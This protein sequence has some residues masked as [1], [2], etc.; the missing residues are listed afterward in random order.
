MFRDLRDS[1]GGDQPPVSLSNAKYDGSRPV[2]TPLSLRACWEEGIEP[3][4]LVKP[5]AAD[6]YFKEGSAAGGNGGNAAADGEEKKIPKPPPLSAEKQKLRLEHNERVRQRL[7]V[8]VRSRYQMLQTKAKE[9]T[10]TANSTRKPQE[11]ENSDESTK[12]SPRIPLPPIS[13]RSPLLAA[14]D[15]EDDEDELVKAFLVLK[16]SAETRNRTRHALE[17]KERHMAEWA[18]HVEEERRQKSEAAAKAAETQR[19]KTLEAYERNQRIR[20]LKSLK[21]V[22]E[23]EKMIETAHQHAKATHKV[24]DPSRG[25]KEREMAAKADAERLANLQTKLAKAQ[26]AAQRKRKQEER[27]RELKAFQQELVLETQ[28]QQNERC[29][30]MLEF[31]KSRIQAKMEEEEKR[32]QEASEA[33]RAKIKASMLARERIMREKEEVAKY[34]AECEA[35]GLETIDAPEW[36]KDSVE[37]YHKRGATGTLSSTPR[38]A[39]LEPRR[40]G[41]LAGDASPSP[42]RTR[43][44]RSSGSG[45]DRFM[46]PERFTIFTAE[47]PAKRCFPKWMFET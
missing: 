32:R 7:L 37:R 13:G 45:T 14:P 43:S 6:P 27:E 35:K 28:E 3:A 34:V 17:K 20:T 39:R 12:E 21:K 29:K 30:K 22:E 46:S 1:R 47:Q 2:N 16:K 25:E 44:A 26:E 33:R 15:G 19:A 38:T 8:A 36:L 11:T 41:S 18:A 10:K 23:K 40:P 9:P 31:R 42:K 24:V 4:Q 5:E